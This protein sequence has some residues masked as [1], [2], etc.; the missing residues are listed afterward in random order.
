LKLYG[1][2][3]DEEEEQKLK[4]VKCPHCETY[5]TEGAR[6]CV[7]CK[8]PLSVAEVAA[9]EERLM[10]FFGDLMDLAGKSPELSQMLQKI[11]KPSQ[12]QK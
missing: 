11:V 2:K 5:N 3:T 9:K 4:T 6:V 1:L 8:M 10:E 12:V 7:K